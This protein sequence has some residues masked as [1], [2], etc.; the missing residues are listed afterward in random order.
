[1]PVARNAWARCAVSG[2]H[3]E[4]GDRP[5]GVNI[6]CKRARQGPRS[7]PP[8]SPERQHKNKP[9]TKQ[10][11]LVTNVG[12]GKRRSAAF[13]GR[14]QRMHRCTIRQAATTGGV[15]ANCSPQ[16]SLPYGTLPCRSIDLFVSETAKLYVKCAVCHVQ[17]ASLSVQNR[18]TVQNMCDVR[19]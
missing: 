12:R 4:R 17:F 2:N 19:R 1:M 6:N 3:A 11:A 18:A 14:E 9:G 13:A 15:P 16:P 7:T 10:C 5:T 8:L